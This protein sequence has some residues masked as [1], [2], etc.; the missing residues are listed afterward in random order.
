VRTFKITSETRG[1]P[2]LKRKRTNNGALE[3]SKE[4]FTEL[5]NSRTR[6]NE[7][8][9]RQLKLTQETE[10]RMKRSQED[11]LWRDYKRFSLSSE[12]LLQLRA[13]QLKARLEALLN[14]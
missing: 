13:K 12:P 1:E 2:K 9:E 14:N 10:E 7:I 8:S 3:A 5:S 6:A 4:L 11:E